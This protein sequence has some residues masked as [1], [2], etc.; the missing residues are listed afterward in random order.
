M[1]TP[2][3]IIWNRIPKRIRSSLGFVLKAI[4]TILAFYL[5]LSHKVQMVDHRSILLTDGR[6]MQL[7]PGDTLRIGTRSLILVS[8]KKARTSDEDP[9]NASSIIKKGQRIHFRDP[10]S[11]KEIA[12]EAL[13]L[14]KETTFAAIIGYLPK[15]KAS[16]FWSFVLL[17]ACIK[18]LGILCSMYR[19]HLL[20]QG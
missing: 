18:F 2:I 20:L 12:G 11:G 15:I 19:W 5:L 4:L 8:G 17:A 6:T 9:E 3:G 10:G 16:T 7:S 1:P 14:D 13:P